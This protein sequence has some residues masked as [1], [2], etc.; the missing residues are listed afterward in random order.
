MHSI[1]VVF[2]VCP[3]SLGGDNERVQLGIY[4]CICQLSIFSFISSITFIIVI[5][6]I[7]IINII[8]IIIKYHYYHNHHHYYYLIFLF[9]Q[10]IYYL[11][12][13][14]IFNFL[15]HF[16]FLGG[17]GWGG[18]GMHGN[19]MGPCALFCFIIEFVLRKTCPW[20][21]GEYIHNSQ[22][23]T[24]SRSPNEMQLL[25]KEKTIS[26][27]GENCATVYWG[28]SPLRSEGTQAHD[29]VFF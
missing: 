5:N 9:I 27:P 1:V 2:F 26:P 3:L 19:V 25:N 29:F 15:F 13:N 17:G 23:S 28:R 4:L 14:F 12:I 22:W 8:I 6:T 20:C 11:F 16:Y 21:H 18:G 10:S 7:I 24:G